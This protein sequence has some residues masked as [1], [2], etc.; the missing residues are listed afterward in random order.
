MTGSSV[1]HASSYEFLKIEFHKMNTTSEM[2]MEN[3]IRFQQA[4][5]LI[6]PVKQRLPR[7]A[8]S[9]LAI[10]EISFFYGTRRL[11]TAFAKTRSWSV[12]WARRVPHIFTPNFFKHHRLCFL[13][14]LFASGFPDHRFSKIHLQA[15]LSFECMQSSIQNFDVVLSFEPNSKTK[16]WRNVATLPRG[17]QHFFPSLASR[18]HP[19]GSA[20]WWPHPC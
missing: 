15:D 17:G 16:V 4:T 5:N 20:S 10:Q 7:E 6:H 19:Q 18:M 11:I 1:I 2:A 12:F 3:K 8:D 14:W 9:S 13:N